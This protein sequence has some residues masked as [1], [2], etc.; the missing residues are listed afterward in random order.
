MM[1][2]K[3]LELF[4]AI[5]PKRTKEKVQHCDT[6]DTL[7]SVISEYQTLQRV[8]AQGQ[9][10]Q[11]V[12]AAPTYLNMPTL[13]EAI[14]TPSRI[15]QHQTR[16]NTPFGVIQRRCTRGTNTMDTNANRKLKESPCRK[17]KHQRQTW[18]RPLPKKTHHLQRCQFSRRQQ[19][20]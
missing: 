5:V 19:I 11:R 15:H 18:T 12:V 2:A 20:S 4:K 17:N 16:Q 14:Q 8:N 1:T 13:R 9:Q 10:P 7:T 6:I 3:L